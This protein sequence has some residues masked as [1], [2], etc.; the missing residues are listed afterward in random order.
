[1]GVQRGRTLRL[2][3]YGNGLKA[4]DQGSRPAHQ[5]VGRNGNDVKLVELWRHSNPVITLDAY[6][7]STTPAKREAQGKVMQR[8]L[9]EN[10]KSA[11]MKAKPASS[12]A[13]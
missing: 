11:L 12:R 9:A 5:Y 8:L 4:T 1:M 2:W 7:R 6:A 3:R 10:E 13:M